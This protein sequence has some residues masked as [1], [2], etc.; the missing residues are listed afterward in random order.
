MILNDIAYCA[1]FF[2]KTPPAPDAKV[3]CHGDLHAMHIVT[4][5]QRLEKGIGEPEIKQILDSLL[6]EKVIDP[7]YRVFGKYFVQRSVE[8]LGGFQIAPK[9]LF[10]HNAGFCGTMR[11]AQTFD[12]GR[13]HARRNGKIKKR[14]L[15]RTE[16]H[17]H[18]LK[19]FNI[20]VVAIDIL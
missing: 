3:F 1:D 15:A 2:V 4:I 17:P 7:K 9:R 19:R 12:D 13:K 5:P 8:L 16:C 20:F 14:P 11:L 10:D 18:R 6:A